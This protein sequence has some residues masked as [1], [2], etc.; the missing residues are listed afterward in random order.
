MSWSTDTGGFRY[1]LLEIQYRALGDFERL[2][3]VFGAVRGL[4]SQR[5]KYSDLPRFRPLGSVKPY[6]CM[7][8]YL[9]VAMS[10]VVTTMVVPG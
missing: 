2:Q 5:K 6:F 3:P 10:E 1:P 9:V 8:G 7:S 4:Q